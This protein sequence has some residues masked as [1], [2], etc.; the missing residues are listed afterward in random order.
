MKTLLAGL[1]IAVLGVSAADAQE[2]YIAFHGAYV[3]TDD[4]DLYTFVGDIPHTLDSGYAMGI[5][6]GHKTEAGFR[7]E[8]EGTYRSNP[9]ETIGGIA[10]S[11]NVVAASAMANLHYDFIV[12]SN[13]DNPYSR[14]RMV[15]YLGL[16]VGGAYLDFQDVTYGGLPFADEGQWVPAAQAILGVGWNIGT[17]SMLSI[18]YRYFKTFDGDFAGQTGIA[19]DA[20][21]VHHTAM[22]SLRTPF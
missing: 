16:G 12:Y 17:D 15:P 8:L 13:P 20:G 21:Y 9:V 14:S 6:L 7:M 3:I 11:G 2:N 1:T 5:A 19:F 4:P 10:A 18:D 22:V